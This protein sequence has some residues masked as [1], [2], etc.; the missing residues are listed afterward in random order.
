MSSI[1]HNPLKQYFRRPG[2]Y[3]KLPTGGKGYSQDV[4]V[5]T[6]TGELPV[7]PMTAIDEISSKTPDALYNGSAVAE[8]IRSCVPSIKD[9]WAISSVDLDAILV[10]IKIAT[11]GNEMDLETTCPNCET[12][13]KF[14]LNLSYV[15]NNFAPGD[16]DKPL[17]IDELRIKF[18]PLTYKQLTASTTKQLEI[19][20]AFMTLNAMDEGS[21]REVKSTELLKII[22]DSTVDVLVNVIEYIATPEAVVSEKAYIKDFLNNTDKRTFEHIRETSIKL[23]ETTQTKPLHIAC[24]NCKHEYDQPFTLNISDFFE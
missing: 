24:T 12:E 14:G 22:S 19:Q 21:E 13:N 11:N 4:L 6:E 15:L 2:I 16:Y 8:I 5:M 23:R 18:K 3:L 20:R 10:A 17:M 1:E 9:P 7:Y